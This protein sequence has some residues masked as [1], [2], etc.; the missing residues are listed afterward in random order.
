MVER[1]ETTLATMHEMEL[2]RGHFYNWYDTFDL[3]P[4][5]PKYVSTVDSG[6]L[7]AHLLTLANACRELMEKSTFKSNVLAGMRDTARLLSDALIGIPRTGRTQ[8]VTRKQLSSAVDAIRTSLELAPAGAVDWAQRF[9]EWKALTQNV[10]DIAQTL[11]QERGDAADSELAAWAN[12]LQVCTESHSR[13]AGILIPLA[14]MESKDVAGLTACLRNHSSDLKA[15]ELLY[16]IPTL[17]GAPDRFD[18]TLRELSELR[19]HLISDAQGGSNAPTNR[20]TIICIET[21]IEVVK[22][23]LTNAVALVRRLSTIIQ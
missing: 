17:A 1:L 20:D 7:A 14:Q 21:L 5:D 11:T 10:A 15:I 3:H 18:A 16:S 19:I 8:V 22:Q 2:F 9:V 12:A 13:D 23:S 4:L 6:N